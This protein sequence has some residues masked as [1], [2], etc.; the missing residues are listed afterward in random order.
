MLIN[1]EQVK[2]IST[3]MSVMEALI[4]E[5]DEKLAI[6]YDIDIKDACI[7]ASIQLINHFK[8]SSYGTAAAYAMELEIKN[9]AR[10]FH[11]AEVNEK[12]IDQRLSEVAETEINRKARVPFLITK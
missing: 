11:E 12:E 3:G 8:I 9:T 2:S 7:L 4:K 10:L 6:C 5:A 1:N